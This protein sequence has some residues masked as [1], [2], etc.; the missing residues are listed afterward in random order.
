MLDEMSII[1][2]N[3]FDDLITKPVNASTLSFKIQQAI[4][5]E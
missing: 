2:S 5:R 3:G 4:E 1:K